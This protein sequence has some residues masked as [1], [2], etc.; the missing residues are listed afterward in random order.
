MKKLKLSFKKMFSS[1]FL[2]LVIPAV[3]LFCAV[4]LASCFNSKS[5]RGIESENL[6]S[7]GYGKFDNQVDLFNVSSVGSINTYIAMRDGFFYI[8]NGESRKIMEMNSYGDLLTLFFNKE[9]ALNFDYELTDDSVDST[10]KAVSYPFNT[11]GVIA[12]DSHKT[13]YVA[14]S[15]PKEQQVAG[16]DENLLYSQVILRFSSDGKV[17]DYIGRQGIG[18]TPF[19]YIK[20]IYTTKDDDLVVVCITNDGLNVYWF[21]SSGQLLYVV[22]INDGELPNPFS[23]QTSEDFFI[24]VDNAIP[25]SDSN[26]NK[27]YVKLDYYG[28][29]VDQDSKVQSGIDY[30]NT[31]LYPLDVA[32]GTYGEPLKIPPFEEDVSDG[33]GKVTYTAPYE[34]MGV[35]DSGWMFFSIPVKDGYRLQIIQMS[36]NIFHHDAFGNLCL[37]LALTLSAQC[38][39]N[40]CLPG[41]LACSHIIY[42]ITCIRTFR[43]DQTNIACLPNRID[44][45]LFHLGLQIAGYNIFIIPIC[46]PGGIIFFHQLFKTLH[47]SF[48]G[49]P[50][51]QD[52]LSI[53]IFCYN[54]ISIDCFIFIQIT[55]YKTERIISMVA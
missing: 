49:I 26:A 38:A 45:P 14:D 19:P 3:F 30:A 8:A 34:F 51:V 18:G 39:D 47:R 53:S 2:P 55:P 7:L 35:T 15:L 17:L 11:L 31:L 43:R 5:A 48:A 33:F 21:N 36:F 13:I 24:T 9:S 46:V 6:F 27:L 52:L 20:K 41:H 23:S 40:F 25:A 12:I 32:T 28:M 50:L 54:N 37:I 10:R 44:K 29:Y 16:T 42:H 1:L 22:P 4:F